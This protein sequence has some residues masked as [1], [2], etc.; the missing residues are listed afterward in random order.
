MNAIELARQAYA[1]AAA[2]VKTDR[3]IEA[4]VLSSITADLQRSK[5][6]FPKL[7]DALHR[8]RLF[9]T[10][11]AADV[12]QEENR[13]PE[14]LRAR[15]FY[16]AEFTFHQ[17]SRILADGKSTDILIEINSAIISSLTARG[18]S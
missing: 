2:A 9:W 8:N 11:L 5:D 3:A 4:Q 16:L 17:T 12:S 10:A 18:T 7:V 13:L 15:I 6:N 1:P 14:T